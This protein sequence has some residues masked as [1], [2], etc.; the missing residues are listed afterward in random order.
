M[1]TEKLTK[2]QFLERAVKAEAAEKAKRK[3]QRIQSEADM[4]AMAQAKDKRI[5]SR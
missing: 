2:E 3:A 4:R 5:R 1:G